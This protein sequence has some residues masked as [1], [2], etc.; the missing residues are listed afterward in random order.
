MY[1]TESMRGNPVLKL[2]VS[3]IIDFNEACG[4]GKNQG[5]VATL[6]TL[7]AEVSRGGEGCYKK[8]DDFLKYLRLTPD[9]AEALRQRREQDRLKIQFYLAQYGELNRTRRAGWLI[10]DR[11]MQAHLAGV[12]A[13]LN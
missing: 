7:W 12:G 6:S 13:A 1:S 4:D 3:R 9:E 5:L 8:I 10:E 11:E 2:C